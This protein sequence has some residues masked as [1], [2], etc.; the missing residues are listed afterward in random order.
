MTRSA[1][2]GVVGLDT[3]MALA[4]KKAQEHLRIQ[5]KESDDKKQP[6]SKVVPFVKRILTDGEALI[7]ADEKPIQAGWS[8]SLEPV[9]KLASDWRARADAE[10]LLALIKATEDISDD[11]VSNLAGLIYHSRKDED[12][13]RIFMAVTHLLRSGKVVERREG[14]RRYLRV[15]PV[16]EGPRSL[17]LA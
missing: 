14:S 5:G 8:A 15:V 7:G 1:E 10:I 11:D 3:L 17:K 6:W 4:M 12:R 16:G 13:E 2:N 9:A